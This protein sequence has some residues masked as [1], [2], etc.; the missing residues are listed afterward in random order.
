MLAS[1]NYA[2]T[3]SPV[4]PTVVDQI[5]LWE[6]ERN[7]IS[8]T[9]GVVY[10]QFLSQVKKGLIGFECEF[11]WNLL[12]KNLFQADFGVLK[13]HA[14]QLGVLVWDN[15]R[16]RTMV[17]TKQGHDDVKKFWKRYSKSS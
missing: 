15:E 4:P 16:S 1:E 17:V 3:P 6:N 9:E 12:M 2:Q 13:D 5:R 10:N 8:Y 11:Y 7:R 14:Q